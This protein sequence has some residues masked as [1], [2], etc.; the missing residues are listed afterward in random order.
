MKRSCENTKRDDRGPYSNG[1]KFGF[2]MKRGATDRIRRNDLVIQGGEF[3]HAMKVE[4]V[5]AMIFP[6]EILFAFQHLQYYN[7]AVMHNMV[8]IN[9]WPSVPFSPFLSFFPIRL[10][11]HE[12]DDNK[13]V[14]QL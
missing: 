1:Y 9:Y 13:I 14:N 3:R 8:T 5:L 2:I 6:A 11:P 7:S 4:I 10:V 12:I